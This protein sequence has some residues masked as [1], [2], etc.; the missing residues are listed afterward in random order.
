MPDLAPA[1]IAAR[2]PNDGGMLYFLHVA[3]TAGTTAIAYLDGH[4]ATHEVC[5]A[6]DWP[7]LFE[8][9]PG[10]LAGYKFLRGPF[11]A[12]VIGLLGE[13]PRIVTMVRDPVERAVSHWRY[14]RRLPK[15]P[16]HAEAVGQD[17][18]TFSLA[19]RPDV[20][21]RRLGVDDPAG[22][23][24]T[25]LRDHST[26]TDL[27]DRVDRWTSGQPDLLARAVARLEQA[28]AFGVTERVDESLDLIA[29][30]LGWPA[31]PGTALA[32]NASPG[33]VEI[34]EH[35]AAAIAEHNRLD[36]ELHRWARQRFDVEY[37][38]IVPSPAPRRPPDERPPV[39]DDLAPQHTYR[40]IRV[41]TRR[42]GRAGAARPRSP[43]GPSVLGA[44][45][46]SWLRDRRRHAEPGL[47]RA[48][49]DP[50]LLPS[51]DGIVD[52]IVDPARQGMLLADPSLWGEGA[53]APFPP[54]DPLALR[55]YLSRGEPLA[56]QRMRGVA[57]G[58]DA[59]VARVG[60]DFG[61]PASATLIA[62]GPGTRL[63]D[64]HFDPVDVIAIQALG[65]K[66]WRLS[67]V[68]RPLLESTEATRRAMVAGRSEAAAHT[69]WEVTLEPGDVIYVPA[70]RYHDVWAVTPLSVHVD[71]LVGREVAALESVGTR[72]R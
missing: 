47:L 33:T 70:G 46:M 9:P 60:R 15:H 12:L 11:G 6:T 67:R 54:P 37:A 27:W 59:A 28:T 2:D 10:R 24:L 62:T 44:S 69:A 29:H 43:V 66:T 40:A 42:D 61:T 4:F 14:V 55:S 31:R 25:E 52:G 68:S 41:R 72:A 23:F 36:V 26:E 17:V 64:T 13:A 50:A 51:L 65:A 16:L 20:Q 22:S 19:R 18:L 57:P 5:P 34:A 48:A 39:H 71:V 53:H 8:L 35:V 3:K 1:P 63:F 32:W 30:R 58:V 21:V 45:T 7:Q 56:W 38:A 49:V